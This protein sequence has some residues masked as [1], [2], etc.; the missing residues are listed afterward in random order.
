MFNAGTIHYSKCHS[1]NNGNLDSEIVKL[2]WLSMHL[3]IT[4]FVFICIALA[5]VDRED[6]NKFKNQEARMIRSNGRIYQCVVPLRRLPHSVVFFK[7]IALGHI[8]EAW[9]AKA[10]QEREREKAPNRREKT[11]L[12]NGRNY[13]DM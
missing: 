5:A 11:H 13:N 2:H 9:L 10:E 1:S 6:V 4:N 7:H 3:F 12:A 8:T